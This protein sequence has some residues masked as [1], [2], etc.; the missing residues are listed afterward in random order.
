M[1]Q[2]S[3]ES[4]YKPKPYSPIANTIWERVQKK[5]NFAELSAES[6]RNLAAANEILKHSTLV[7]YANHT[8]TKDVTVGIALMLSHLTNARNF[9]APAGMKHYDMRRDPKN[10]ILFRALRL[11]NM[12]AI[13]IV[14]TDDLDSYSPEKREKLLAKLKQRTA[15][16]LGQPRSIYGIF[17]EGTRNKKTGALLKAKPGIAKIEKYTDKPLY[18]LPIAIVYEK[19][20]EPQVVVGE[21]QTLAE[22]LERNGQAIP[23]DQAEQIADVH[24]QRLAELLPKSMRGSYA[25]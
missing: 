22:I 3:N 7:V 1:R 14:Q 15:Q 10:G 25:R 18:Y 5:H 13:P 20:D 8:S 6:K 12:H 17:P 24:M 23:K 2:R 19:W 9:L 16:L 11:L 4:E 21:P